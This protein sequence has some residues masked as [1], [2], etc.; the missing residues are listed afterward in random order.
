MI[1]A[2]IQTPV[3]GAGG[4]QRMATQKKVKNPSVRKIKTSVNG[5]ASATA[6]A[7]AVPPVAHFTASED[8]VKVRAYEL[9]VARGYTHGADLEDWFAAERELANRLAVRPS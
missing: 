4:G 5:T 2:E 1:P 8:A 7:I 3:D 6:E 9:F